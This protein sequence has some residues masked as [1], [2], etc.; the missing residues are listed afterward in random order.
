MRELPVPPFS[1]AETLQD[2]PISELLPSPSVVGPTCFKMIHLIPC[3]HVAERAR[4]GSFG[5][6]T[7]TVNASDPSGRFMGEMFSPSA[8][9]ASQNSIPQIT[10]QPMSVRTTPLRQGFVLAQAQ[11]LISCP[12]IF[13]D[14]MSGEQRHVLNSRW[15]IRIS[16][17]EHRVDYVEVQSETRVDDHGFD[18][19]PWLSP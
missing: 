6:L 5:L 1:G 14:A 10:V 12:T 4:V 16:T 3:S 8:I 17:A 11:G 2:P 19:P 18:G 13:S 7:Y 15:A 9:S